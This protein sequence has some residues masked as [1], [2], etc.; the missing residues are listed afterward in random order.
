MKNCLVVDDSKVIRKVARHILET[1]QFEVREAGDGR[2]ALDR[3]AERQ[4]DVIL[5]DWN[6]PVMS[7]MDFVRALPVHDRRRRPRARCAC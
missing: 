7:G 3:C 6:M 4:P 1:L 2:E 5:L